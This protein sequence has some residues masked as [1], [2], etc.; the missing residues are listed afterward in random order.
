MRTSKILL[1]E[2]KIQSWSHLA[3]CGLNSSLK[4]FKDIKI[5]K[6]GDSNFLIEETKLILTFTNMEL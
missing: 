3:P 2:S 4:I 5:T 6:L 1:S